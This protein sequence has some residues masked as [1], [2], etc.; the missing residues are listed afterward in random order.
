MTHAEIQEL[1]EGALATV[2]FNPPVDVAYCTAVRDELR[3]ALPKATL[4]VFHRH[5]EFVV[6]VRIGAVVCKVTLPLV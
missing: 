6:D 4:E 2:P 3:K 1:V 5:R